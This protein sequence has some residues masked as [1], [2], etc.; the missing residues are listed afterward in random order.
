V[1]HINIFYPDK[2]GICFD[3]SDLLVNCNASAYGWNAMHQA[4]SKLTSVLLL[5]RWTQTASNNYTQ[6]LENSRRYAPTWNV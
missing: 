2:F 1:N 4:W 5:Y 3:S 6:K